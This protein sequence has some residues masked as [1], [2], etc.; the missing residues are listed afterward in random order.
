M[1]KR[2][3]FVAITILIII[4]ASGIGVYAD[5]E[6][7]IAGREERLKNELAKV[8]KEIAAQKSLLKAKQQ[9]TASIQ[10]DV[11]ILTYKI[12]TAQLN[13]KQ[14]KLE[15]ERLGGDIYEKSQTIGKLDEKVSGNKVSLRELLRQ[16][17]AMDD[18][19][20]LE[21]TLGEESLTSVYNEAERFN[22]IQAAMHGTLAET[23]V[24]K[25][26][27]E[28]E[29]SILEERREAVSN[30]KREIEIETANIERLNAEKTKYLKLSKAQEGA[31][32]KVIA[33][34]EKERAAIRSALFQLRNATNITFGEALDLA[35]LVNKSTGVRPAF[36][37]AI[38]TQESNLG[39]NV[40]TCNRPGDPPAKG[41]REIMKPERDRAPFLRITK[42]LGLDPETQPVSCPYMGGWGGA[43]GP[44]QFIPSTWAA[45]E[46]RIAAATGHNPPNPW[47]PLD[48]FTA[49][50]LYLKDLGAAAGTY[51]AE[52]RAALKYYAGSN[53]ANPKNAFYGNQVMALVAKY[54]RQIDILQND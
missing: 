36:V 46:S 22:D 48:A 20:L 32:R 15:I 42:S 19:I 28:K 27:T 38:I 34:K 53:W 17:R 4:F 24:N 47:L 45:Y 51:T 40:G 10:R 52:R 30:A 3:F 18:F 7:E 54:D 16:A 39:Q 31:Y 49:S 37:L 33:D 44:A 12:N 1:F 14:K 13:I 26:L 6:S 50:A 29:K 8:E 2:V 5:T 35:K 9:E 21:I 25:K 41:Y 23:R 11:D 43:M